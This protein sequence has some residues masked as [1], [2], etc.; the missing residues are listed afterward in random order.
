MENL[1]ACWGWTVLLWLQ[2]RRVTRQNKNPAKNPAEEGH[3]LKENACF[4]FLSFTPRV[5]FHPG[6]SPDQ[7]TCQTDRF[8]CKNNR[9]I[10]LRWLCDGDNDCGNDEDESNTT[11]SGRETNSICENPESPLAVVETFAL[12]PF[13]PA[14]APLTS[15][16]VLAGAASRFPGRATWMMTVAIGQTNPPLVVGPLSLFCAHHL[17]SKVCG[18]GHRPV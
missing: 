13:Q 12:L 3:K 15:T 11:C 5:L 7:H 17:A 8:K 18:F 6:V 9:C 2:C 16:R 1:S 4:L 10:P 14:P